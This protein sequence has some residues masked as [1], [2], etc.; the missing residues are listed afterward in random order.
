[1]S[2]FAYALRSFIRAGAR[3][4]AYLL[5]LALAVAFVSA[6]LF[7]VDGATRDLTQRAIAPVMLDF[8]AR[9]VDPTTDIAALAPRLQG[10]PGVTAALPFASAAIDI[11]PAGKATGGQPIPA[12]LLA[13]PPDYPATFPLLAVSAG[14]FGPDGVLVSEQLAT[15]LGLKLGDTFPLTVP[16]LDHPYPVLITGLVNTDRA[17]P[18]FTGPTAAPEGSYNVAAAVVVIDYARFG[19]D[20]A[21]PLTRAAAAPVTGGTT[22]TP[23]VLPLLDR[24]LHL[25]LDRAALPSDPGAAATVV[26]TLRRQLERQA[27]GQLRITDN[28]AT[29]FTSAGVDVVAA[30]LLFVF[31]G[32]P[33]VLLAAYLAQAAAG[34]VSEAQRRD[35][36]LLR[37]RGAGPRRL[38]ATLGWTAAL[39]ALLGTLLGLAL[40]AATT[41]ALFGRGAFHDTG[42]IARSALA[43][44][45]L[46]MTLGGVGIFLPARR[47]VAGEIAE[48]R[49]GVVAATRPLW[50]RLPLDLFLLAGA[51][52]ALWLSGAYNSKVA[53]AGA[54]ETAA[55]SL[56]IY[57]FLGPLL[58]WSGAALLFL[59]LAGWALGRPAGPWHGGLVGLASRSLR[60][61]GGRVAGLA[62]LLALALSFGVAVTT[63]GATYDASRRADARYTVG[64]DLR[65]IPAL[66]NPQPASFATRLKVPGVRAVAPVW[67]ANDAV[68]G[69]QTQ[70][71]Y[72][73]DV[74]ALTA[75]T[76]IPDRFF[77]D[78]DAGGALARLAAT[79][80]G[81]LVSSELATAYNIQLGDT[82][83]LHLPRRGGGAT[84]LKPHVVGIFSMFPTS[85][86]NS[87]LVV[88]APFLTAA[89]GNPDPG[90]FLL[91]T[92]GRAATNDA[93]ATTLTGQFANQ[94]AARIETANGAISRDQSSLVGLNLAG[95]VALD[96]LY[97]A[98]L[99]GLGLGVFLWG[100][101]LERG[102]ELGTLEALGAT[103]GQVSGLLLL[104]GA[105]LTVVGIVGG[106]L[107]G[108]PLAWQYNGFLP[109]I[110]AVPQPTLAIPWT[111]L[112]ALLALALVG[113]LMAAG[114]AV[115]RL[116]RLWP[117]EALRDA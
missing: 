27:S 95:L 52:L 88:N 9:A 54:S 28:L 14:H 104:E 75:A 117:A 78:G 26:A 18:L 40:G 5:G 29:A 87:D 80:D 23:S 4:A 109:G 7:F 2:S 100:G 34:L 10:Q 101:I 57:A 76:T 6:T 99:V 46:G 37:V 72:G 108:A 33:G 86:Q 25:R 3:N 77:P 13:V 42:S 85:S 98:L 83:A 114:L 50:A 107:I 103:R 1:M 35:I 102:R 84:D 91:G 110:F 112:G 30:R 64:A 79:P 97:A 11:M 69:S 56:G 49:R 51:A 65:V 31:L 48:E 8:Q 53:T 20:L 21:A 70:A 82:V 66:T 63:F 60:R 67:V 94:L 59:R 36:A 96:R 55:V 115:L 90:F 32:L 38:L 111:G 58:F 44:S 22:S 15:S 113:V 105:V 47:M 19:R 24:Q 45:V 81:L 116:R 89:T 61:R 43:A 41:A 39:T 17:E 68:V 73:V 71:V 92:D 93:V 106:V 12:R 62:L 74:A 16:G